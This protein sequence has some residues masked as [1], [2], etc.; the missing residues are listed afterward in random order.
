MCFAGM[1]AGMGCTTLACALAVRVLWPRALQ[2]TA[3]RFN[4]VAVGACPER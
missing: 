1:V 2:L 4:L 3:R